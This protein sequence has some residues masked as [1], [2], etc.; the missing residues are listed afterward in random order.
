MQ[1][2]ATTARVTPWPLSEF[3]SR[4]ASTESFFADSMNPQVFTSA[5]SADST[6][7]TS[8]QPSA[9]RRPANSSESTSLRAHPIVTT[10]TVRFICAILPC[11]WALGI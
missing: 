4:S 11:L 3:A 8:V 6:S 9:S 1:P 10:A 2:T 7:A 5:T